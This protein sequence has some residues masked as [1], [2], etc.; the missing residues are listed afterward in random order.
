VEGSGWT[1]STNVKASEVK[2]RMLTDRQTNR[3]VQAERTQQTH[4]QTECTRLFT[5]TIN[6][7]ITNTKS[8]IKL[9]PTNYFINL[10]LTDRHTDTREQSKKG[11]L[12]VSK[13]V[14][15]FKECMCM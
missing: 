11:G 2:G 5:N 12:E 7:T 10:S 4:T 9:Q 6:N 8:K 14:K 3:Q 13:Q 15:Q 1:W